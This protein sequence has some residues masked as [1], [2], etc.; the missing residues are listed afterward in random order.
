LLT[1]AVPIGT[2]ALQGRTMAA[3]AVIVP[4]GVLVLTCDPAG[5]SSFSQE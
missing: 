3:V 1:A 4:I 5:T 2:D